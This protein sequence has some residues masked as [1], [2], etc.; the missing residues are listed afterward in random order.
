MTCPDK[1][2]KCNGLLIPETD[3]ESIIYLGPHEKCKICGHLTHERKPTKKE[4]REKTDFG[5]DT[6]H[7]FKG[8]DILFEKKSH[9]HR[10]CE[11]HAKMMSRIHTKRSDQRLNGY[12]GTGRL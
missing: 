6:C 5:H 10:Y 11:K 9:N 8:C 12:A 4:E 7:W 3:P 1:C 2:P